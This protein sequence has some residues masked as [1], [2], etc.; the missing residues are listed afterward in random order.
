M[1]RVSV[2][3]PVYNTA[4]YVERCINSLLGQTYR[5]LDIWAVDDGST[6]D[7]WAVLERLEKQDAR[8]H[9]LQVAH[10]GVS[11]ARNA[12][13]A[14]VTGDCLAFLDSDDWLESDAL[15]C[16]VRDLET[17]NADVVFFNST[18]E[19]PTGASLRVEQPLVGI[20]DREEML[21]QALATQG[22]FLSVTNK[23][24]RVSSLTAQ[25]KALPRFDTAVPILEDGLWLIGALLTFSKGFLNDRGFYHRTFRTDSA[26]GNDA[27]WFENMCCYIRSYSRIWQLLCADEC[28]CA[29]DMAEAALLNTIKNA[30][31]HDLAE[32]HGKRLEQLWRSMDGE[33]Q[34]ALF[35]PLLRSFVEYT[36]S[37]PYLLGQKLYRNYAQLVETDSKP[38]DDVSPEKCKAIYHSVMK[39]VANEVVASQGQEP[40]SAA[41]HILGIDGFYGIYFLRGGYRS[42]ANARLQPQRSPL[43][44]LM[45][46]SRRISASSR[47]VYTGRYASH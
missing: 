35:G 45:P 13:L 4:P 37:K 8:L 25:G 29:R 23:L 26:T 32:T 16:L 39:R 36:A 28:A 24:F 19:R 46:K 27:R 15:E 6:D 9:C 31:Q 42:L 38:N 20:V 43:S 18:W 47:S 22:Y 33:A 10:G 2:I 44:T 30:M 11:A 1:K 14:K 21:R 41:E 3:V 34:N 12:A 40:L 7:S 17:H 5:D